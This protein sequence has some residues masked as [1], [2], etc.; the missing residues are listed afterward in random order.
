VQ[1]ATTT[2][3]DEFLNAR[4]AAAEAYTNGDSQLL[5]AIVTRNGAATFHSP[6]GD[7]VAG[8]DA[9]ATRYDSDAASFVPGGESSLEVLQKSASGDLAFWTGFQHATVRLRGRDQPIATHI[10]VTEVFR[11]NNGQWKLIH[12]HAD[13]PSS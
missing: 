8:A 9:V 12:R 6:R 2:D 13:V 10:R 5:D 7:T 1:M 11:R 4:R 3:F